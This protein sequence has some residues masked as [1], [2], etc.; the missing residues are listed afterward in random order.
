MKYRRKI[1]KCLSFEKS[2]FYCLNSFYWCK[3]VVFILIKMS[4]ISW[5]IYKCV[6]IAYGLYLN[7]M[8]QIISIKQQWVFKTDMILYFQVRICTFYD[9]I[10]SSNASK[11]VLYLFIK[12]LVYSIHVCL[13]MLSEWFVILPLDVALY[14]SK[15]IG[16]I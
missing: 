15:T 3:N 4:R 16:N 5:Y 1:W 13:C 14:Q 10:Y 6:I 2:F 8:K 11:Q 7:E 9:D 12:V